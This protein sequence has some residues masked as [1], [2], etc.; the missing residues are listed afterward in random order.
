LRSRAAGSK[1]GAGPREVIGISK[2]VS[3]RSIVSYVLGMAGH[4]TFGSQAQ[5]IGQF[6]P[7][8]IGQFYAAIG[9]GISRPCKLQKIRHTT[10]QI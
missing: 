1:C 2:I 3:K 8:T 4:M 9:S 10:H 6:I 7:V 5:N